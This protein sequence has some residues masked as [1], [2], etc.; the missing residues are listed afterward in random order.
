MVTS[1][2]SNHHILKVA[3]SFRP[4]VTSIRFVLKHP[5]PSPIT[6]PLESTDYDSF[7]TWT[8]RVHTT[9]I[10]SKQE[11]IFYMIVKDLTDTGI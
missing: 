1:M 10:L 4:L 3:L 11:D 6:L 2:L 9:I 5:E 7:L 8:S